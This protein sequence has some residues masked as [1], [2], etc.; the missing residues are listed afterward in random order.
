MDHELKIIES[1]KFQPKLIATS[2][3]YGLYLCANRQYTRNERLS[4]LLNFLQSTR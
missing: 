4:A 2:H 1:C 3:S